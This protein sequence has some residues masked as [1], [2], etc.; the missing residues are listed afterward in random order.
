MMGKKLWMLI[1]LLTMALVS[2]TWAGAVKVGDILEEIDEISDLKSDFTAKAEMTQQKAGE[3]V[4]LYQAIYY[5]RDADDSF[6]MI[7]TG[8]EVEKGNGYLKQG[9]NMWKYMRNTRSFQHINRDENIAG[10][11]TRGEDFERR[12]LTELY[13]PALDKEGKEIIF[14]TKLGAVPVYQIELTAKVENVSY[15]KRIYWVRQDNYLPLKVQSYSLNGTLMETDYYLKYTQIEGKY[16]LIKG[17]FIDEF[18]KGNKTIVD[19][20]DISIKKIGDHVFTK[21]Y[22]ESLSK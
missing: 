16:Q 8:P 1:A 11:N 5:R 20:K 15:P 3:G 22:L 2:P 14:E 19:I 9:E 21:A 10:T 12:K 13:K 17:I 7:F 18:E 6:L 4:K